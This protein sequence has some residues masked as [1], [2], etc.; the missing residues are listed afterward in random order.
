VA[1]EIFAGAGD[2][3]RCDS[4]SDEATAKLL[5][6]M[7]GTVFTLGD[8]AYPNGTDTDFANCYGP[9]WGRHK[10]RTRPTAGNVEY[11]TTGAT[12]YYN[13][14]GAAAGPAG[15]GYYSFELGAWHIISLNSNIS[16]GPTSAQVKWLRADL[17][18]HRNQCT[19]AFWH[20]PLY[21]SNNGTGTGGITYSSVRTFWDTLYAYGVDVVL[22]GHRH[23][24]ERMARMKPNGTPDAAF[25]I[26]EL[27]AGMGGTG[28]GTLTNLHPRSE[29]RNG[30]TRGVLKLHLHDGSYAWKFVPVAGKT[31]SDTGSTNCHPAPGA[32]GGGISPSLSTISASPTSLTAGTGTS[33][34]TVTARN[35]SGQ[36]VSAANVVLLSTGTGNTLT[37][38]SGP[39]GANGV[40]S[41]T[42]GSTGAGTKTISAVI[43]GV[44]IDQTAEIAVSP[45]PAS[46][47]QSTVTANPGSISAGS[48]VSTITVTARDQ[49]ANRLSGATVLLAVNPAAGT[50]LTQPGPTNGNGVATGSLSSTAP[51]VKSVSATVNGTA[52]AQQANV[53]V[54]PQGG[55]GIAH[56]LLTSGNGT[57]NTTVYTT[58]SIAP[59]PNTL[60]TVAV[61]GHRT[62]S[63]AGAPTITGGGM[64][65]WEQ[66]ATATFDTLAAPLKRLTI[67]RAMSDA[68][69][70]GPLTITFPNTV[71][72]AQWIVS[73]WSGAD[74]SG[75][76]GSGAIVQ[77]AGNR[78]DR[79]GS[80]TA[81]LGPLSSSNVAYGVVGVNGNALVVTP[82]AGFTE[83]AEQN[84]GEAAKAVLQ[85]E[86]ATADNT[87]DASWAGTLNGAILGVE[88]KAA[89]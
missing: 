9:T 42:L 27:I 4:N 73:Q 52:V 68:P 84:S 53:T 44:T 75:T 45:G 77:T 47:S 39:T 18:A 21:S 16:R 76:N 87:V 34:L 64:P 46:A 88:I 33:A 89:P 60:I 26:R 31:F 22:G 38:P 49:Y 6:V 71:S 32:G 80:L 25:G 19:L 29:V 23:W 58:A 40:A 11:N 24:Y 35:A 82:G 54:T 65:A 56:T 20:H 7:P 57:V 59:A 15:K 79:V 43:N 66:V 28:G 5:D 78:A 17:A 86:R 12:P 41:G 13:Y 37:Q 50:A 67:Y 72:N 74:E 14:F 30:N 70:S 2:I 83:I 85:A 10:A 1:T 61:L 3:S 62:P 81:T 63:A 69:G 51:G 55:G 48:G 36:P 8:N